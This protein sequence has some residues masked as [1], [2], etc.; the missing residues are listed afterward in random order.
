MGSE[1]ARWRR[2]GPVTGHTRDA[3]AW[4]TS[5]EKR[6]RENLACNLNL[7]YRTAEPYELSKGVV[8]RKFG[9]IHQ[10]WF[11]VRDFLLWI[12]SRLVISYNWRFGTT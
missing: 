7:M 4:A 12:A 5:R 9:Q 11:V 8:G 2:V 3:L 1:V 10:I 6:L